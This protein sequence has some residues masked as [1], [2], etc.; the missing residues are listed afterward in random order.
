MASFGFGCGT[1]K[2]TTCIA[3][4]PPVWLICMAFIVLFDEGGAAKDSLPA[5]ATLG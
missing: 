1:G 2:S 4:G 3:S 5:T